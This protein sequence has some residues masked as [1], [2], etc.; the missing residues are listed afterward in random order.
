MMT[1][2]EGSCGNGSDAGLLMPVGGGFA[3]CFALG[4]L[5]VCVRDW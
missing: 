2:L 4:E 3:E 1:S 5:L